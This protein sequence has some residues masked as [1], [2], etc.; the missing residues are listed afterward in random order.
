MGI[1]GKKNFNHSWEEA[2]EILRRDPAC[3]ELIVDSYLT[4]DLLENCV[5]FS[6]GEEFAEVLR[7]LERCAR[8]KRCLLDVPSGNGI[9]SYSFAKVGFQV[10]AV[11]PNSSNSVGR[12]AVAYVLGVSGTRADIVGG[13]GEKL[14]FASESFDIVYVRQGLHHASDL[15]C[16]MAEIARVLRPA[17]IMLACREHVVDNY[18]TSLKKFLDSQV[19]HQLYGGENAFTL[20]DYMHAITYAQLEVVDVYGPY[21]SPINMYPNDAESLREKILA[22]GPGRT[23][24]LF[25]PNDMVVRFGMW[26]LRRMKAPGRLFTFVARKPKVGV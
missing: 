13:L 21:D 6:K 12:G 18:G 15:F 25:L 7:I 19:D 5:R 2:I 8:G 9:A 10:T 11:E 16:M 22:S 4:S 1:S 3:Q 17:G 26:R 24:R 23:L 20:P 14:P